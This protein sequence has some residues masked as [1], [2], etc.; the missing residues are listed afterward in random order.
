MNILEVDIRP[1]IPDILES[2]I[3]VWGEEF[4]DIV[5]TRK[6]PIYY[7]NYVNLE[8]V[9]SYYDFLNDCRNKDLS[10]QFLERIGAQVSSLKKGDLFSPLDS[11][12]LS[13]IHSF[14]GSPRVFDSNYVKDLTGIFSFDEE[15]ITEFGFESEKEQIKFLNFLRG[16]TEL[17]ASNY[18]EFK[19]TS[20]FSR[21]LGDINH[22]LDIYRELRLKC[23]SYCK[24]LLRYINFINY[25]NIRKK[26]I[27]DSNSLEM[28]Q[29]LENILPRD[30]IELLNY[31][32]LEE[33]SSLFGQLG[34][35]NFIEYF[36]EEDEIILQ[37]EVKDASPR[38]EKKIIMFARLYYLHQIGLFDEPNFSQLER[39][40]SSVDWSMVQRY[41][42]SSDVIKQITAVRKRKYLE[43]LKDF[44]CYSASFV[45]ASLGFDPSERTRNYLYDK[46]NGKE[47]CVSAGSKSEGVYFPILFFTVRPYEYGMLDYIYIHELI[48][49]IEFFCRDAKNCFCGFDV[50]DSSFCEMNPYRSKKRKYERLNETIVDIFAI[51][52]WKS[53]HRKGIYFFEPKELIR[54]NVE[55]YNTNHILKEMV[56]PL[57]DEYAGEVIWSRL[58]NNLQL[59]WDKIGK[60]NFEDLNDCINKVDSL[61][62]QGLY[63]TKCRLDDPLIIEYQQEMERLKRIYENIR[64]SASF[65]SKRGF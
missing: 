58:T 57:L 4:R 7:I 3:E 1:F 50:V 21:L 35:K 24:H 48:H 40:Y 28:Y 65:G 20:E 18:Q 37:S 17:T 56:S 38:H 46:F 25:E 31:K 9:K 49:A 13:M 51:R 54:E 52:V 23:P 34:E 14:L 6:D 39:E 8:G 15:V 61:L 64:C 11:S 19:Q 59:L 63:S 55:D 47:V 41:I 29:S 62:D 12:S 43:S 36:S 45:Q 26:Q 33:K 16:N 2:L 32:S 22:Y 44:I 42:P 60:K 27:E 53:L 5:L 30:L 10:L